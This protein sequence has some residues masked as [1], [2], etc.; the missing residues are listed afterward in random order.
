[1]VIF[2]E[3]LTASSVC[4]LFFSD[5]E[6]WEFSCLNALTFTVSTQAASFRQVWP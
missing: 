3:F 1:V 5:S 6:I 4:I 2:G